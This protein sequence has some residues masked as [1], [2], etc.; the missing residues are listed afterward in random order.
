MHRLAYP[1]ARSVSPTVQAY[2]ER[3]AAEAAR[4]GQQQLAPLPDAETIEALIDA[5]FWASLRREEGYV[6][7][8]S[9]AF[10]RPEQA[11]QP[12]LFERYLP[13]EPSALTR[14]GPAVERPGIHLGV[15]CN[16]DELCVW[17]TTRTVPTL[18]LVVEVAAPGLIVIKHHSGEES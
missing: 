7:K 16:G 14:V 18:C 4:R 8:I 13:L 3:H 9:L 15:W 1:A 11:I 5:A 2:F 17:G 10:L 12:L 6:P